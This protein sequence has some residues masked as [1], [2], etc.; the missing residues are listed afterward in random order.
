MKVGIGIVGC[1][2]VC[3]RY[4]EALRRLEGADLLGVTDIR[5]DRAEICAK[6]F[7]GISYAS[8]GELR[9]DTR[10]QVVVNLTPPSQHAT[11]TRQALQAGRHVYSEKP[12]AFDAR[13]ALSLVDLA[14]GENLYL[15]CA[16]SSVLGPS[17]QELLALLRSGELGKVRAAYAESDWGPSEYAAP[18]PPELMAIGPAADVGIY[19]LALL[20]SALGNVISVRAVGAKLTSEGRNADHI[21]AILNHRS[22]AVS[23]LTCSFY[24]QH[25]PLGS[26]V[27]FHGDKGTARLDSWHGDNAAIQVGPRGGQLTTRP[28]MEPTTPPVDWARGVAELLSAVRDGHEP[29]TGGVIAAHHVEVLQA[30]AESIHTDREVRLSEHGDFPDIRA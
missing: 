4:V 10:V 28:R 30:I 15:G 17:Q 6:S 18:H 8:V 29:R 27:T 26:S 25:R 16:P 3:G 11:V 19:P 9:A 12:L 2:K 20:I 21:I 13:E 24:V 22:L 5:R 7:D 23:R 14:S 1:G